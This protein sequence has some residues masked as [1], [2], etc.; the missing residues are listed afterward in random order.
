MKNKF[1]LV[2]ILSLLLALPVVI[3]GCSKDEPEYTSSDSDSDS[4]S[5]SS[6]SYTLVKTVKA[7]KLTVV[8]SKVTKSS[9]ESV[10]VYKKGSKKYLKIGSSYYTLHSNSSSK[11]MGVSVSGYNYYA[12]K[13]VSK[14]NYYYYVKV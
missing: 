13:V 1:W 4:S 2:S 3:S 7:K 8:Q 11:F 5:S 12:L 10:D 6:S 9:S 14:T